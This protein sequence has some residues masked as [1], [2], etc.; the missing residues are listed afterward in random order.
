[1]GAK[2]Y[3]CISSSSSA[4]FPGY[5][6]A[7]DYTKLSAAA[8]KCI[9]NTCCRKILLPFDGSLG[10]NGRELT[11]E[12]VMAGLEGAEGPRNTADAPER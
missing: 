10:T 3:P 8:A 1:M 2:T 11:R 5:H 7:Y 6:L 12:R 4:I 9:V